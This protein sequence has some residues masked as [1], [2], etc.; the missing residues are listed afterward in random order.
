MLLGFR[1]GFLEW[2]YQRFVSEMS[3]ASDRAFLCLSLTVSLVSLA[4]LQEEKWESA[5]DVPR[6]VATVVPLLLY[7][8]WC[9]LALVVMRR[10]KDNERM[11]RWRDPVTVMNW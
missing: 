4:Y 2:R 10:R 9:V 6:T 8:A 3:M 5:L 1:D 11:C 7:V